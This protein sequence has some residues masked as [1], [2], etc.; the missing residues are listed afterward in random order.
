M[1]LSKKNLLGA[2]VFDGALV[3]QWLSFAVEFLAPAASQRLVRSLRGRYESMV[4]DAMHQ[5]SPRLLLLLLLVSALC[6][7]ALDCSSSL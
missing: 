3:E 5:S 2:T 6:S 4:E 7:A 1:K